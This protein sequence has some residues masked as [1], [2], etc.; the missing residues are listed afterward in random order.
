MEEV[1]THAQAYQDR[2]SREAQNLEMLI[3]C[4][5]AST[6]RMVYNQIYLQR[7]KYIIVGKNTMEQVEYGY[8]S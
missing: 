2:S 4:L 5:K 8:V 1:R 3:Q 6:T 7:E